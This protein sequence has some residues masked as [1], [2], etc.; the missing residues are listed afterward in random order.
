MIAEGEVG[1]IL[2]LVRL[3]LLSVH[4]LKKSCSL[5]RPYVIVGLPFENKRLIY[6][7]D[8]KMG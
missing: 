4:I 1:F 8:G 6:T 7:N 2:F 5:G 3:W